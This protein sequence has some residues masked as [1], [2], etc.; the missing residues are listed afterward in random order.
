M[1]IF[2]VLTLGA[3]LIGGL[4]QKR[5]ADSAAQAAREV[6]EFNAKLI[7]RD[8][9]LLEK[10]RTIINDN[11]VLAKKRARKDFDTLRGEQ[12]A[13][14]AYSGVD[15]FMGTPIFVGLESANEFDFT[16]EQ[17]D[18]ENEL[19]NMEINDKQEDARLQAELSRM[20]GGAQ[21]ASLQAQ[22]TKSLIS[23]LGQAARLGTE[24][25]GGANIGRV[26]QS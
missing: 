26:G 17:M 19:I 1:N 2:Q 12:R 9:D 11:L 25:Y 3:T 5:A 15:L 4:Q 6:G 24:F 8:I 23:S 7:E 13:G 20:E 22:G 10:Q 18:F 14:F 16:L 21:A